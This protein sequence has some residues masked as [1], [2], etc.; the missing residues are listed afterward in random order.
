LHTKTEKQKTLSLTDL[1]QFNVPFTLSVSRVA[2][3]LCV[4]G[5]TYI[6]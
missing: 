2:G 6:I 5:A 1:G 3:S 4:F